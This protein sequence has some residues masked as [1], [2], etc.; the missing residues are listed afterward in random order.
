MIYTTYFGKIAALKKIRPNAA[1]VSIAGWTPDWFIKDGGLQYKKLAPKYVWW[2]EWHD[3]FEKDLECEASKNWYIDKYN[4]T[5]LS[6]LD[7]HAVKCDLYSLA[8]RRDVFILCY[9]TPEKFCHRHLIAEWLQKAGI[10]VQEWD[11]EQLEKDKQECKDRAFVKKIV[12]DRSMSWTERL[13]KIQDFL[14]SKGGGLNGVTVDPTF[15]SDGVLSQAQSV[16]AI[17]R[18]MCLTILS[19]FDP[20]TTDVQDITEQVLNGNM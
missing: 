16:E 5:V 12:D 14:K 4:E 10:K 15:N 11:A 19:T 6:K 8:N 7:Q 20:D 2:K 9:E 18:E 1:L 3:T 17:A 13:A